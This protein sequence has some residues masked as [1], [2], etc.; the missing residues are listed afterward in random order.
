LTR[1]KDEI[2]DYLNEV[3]ANAITVEHGLEHILKLIEER[4]DERIDLVNDQ[5]LYNLAFRQGYIKALEW[6]KKEILK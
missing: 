6:T 3:S 5:P 1:I 4:I 2:E